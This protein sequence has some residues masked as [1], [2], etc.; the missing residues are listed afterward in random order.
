[1]FQ[2]RQMRAGDGSGQRGALPRPVWVDSTGLWS[3]RA[4]LPPSVGILL[5]WR[6]V[7]DARGQTSW[8]GLVVWANDPG[9]GRWS[10]GTTWMRSQCIRQ[11]TVPLDDWKTPRT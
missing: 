11:M 1:M 8:D 9:G 5:E 6:R 10:C 2:H 3:H 4:G 7:V